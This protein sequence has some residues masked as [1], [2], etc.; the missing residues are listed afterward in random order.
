ML[1][2]ILQ[3]AVVLFIILVGVFTIAGNLFGYGSRYLDALAIARALAVTIAGYPVGLAVRTTLE[4]FV[5]KADL[6]AIGMV[7]NAQTM[8]WATIVGWLLTSGLIASCVILGEARRAKREMA[9]VTDER[10][11]A[12][13]TPAPSP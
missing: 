9:H 2:V 10:L 6:A 11:R 12:S 4:T 7:D 5:T 3:D 13:S 8:D 1:Q